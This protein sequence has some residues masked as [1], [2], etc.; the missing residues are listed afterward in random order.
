MSGVVQGTGYRVQVRALLLEKL[1]GLQGKHRV[2]VPERDDAVEICVLGKGTTQQLVTQLPDFVAVEIVHERADELGR[3]VRTR[4][5][6]VPLEGSKNIAA[7][8]ILRQAWNY[9]EV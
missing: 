2:S 6:A 9:K 7:I 1:G 5:D 4:A 8:S 3:R